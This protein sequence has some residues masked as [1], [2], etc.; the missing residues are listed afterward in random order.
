MPD[1]FEAL[2]STSR[3]AEVRPESLELCGREAS[4]QFL[5]KTA[6]LNDAVTKQAAQHPEWTDEHVR[7]VAEFANQHTYA[8]LFDKEAGVVRNPVFEYADPE[9]ILAVVHR[10][11]GDLLVK[12]SAA[13]GAPV[14]DYR[15]A[16][17][18]TESDAMLAD[19]FGAKEPGE[20]A[21]GQDKAASIREWQTTRGALEH[22]TA[23]A[24][25]LEVMYD[26]AV[27][28]F[29]DA[30]KQA[31]LDESS[32]EEVGFVINDVVGIEKLSHVAVPLGAAVARFVQ[33]T[34]R[35]V[36][37]DL[38]KLSAVQTR[39]VDVG[40]EL[41]KSAH[42]LAEVS[43]RRELLGNMVDVLTENVA[44]LT[45]LVTGAAG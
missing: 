13:Y 25:G 11:G 18:A 44:A 40:S 16:L 34:G 19:L 14:P 43:D 2:L 38:E 6:S 22:V 12:A 8:H 36:D 45:S 10:A 1:T 39:V 29:E 24:S 7:R 15:D 23:E 3:G 20:A 5:L 37:L 32:I 27:E 21:E 31:M 42:Y 26:Q 4:Q 41:A 9:V 28:R 30:V 33:E 17:R 35:E